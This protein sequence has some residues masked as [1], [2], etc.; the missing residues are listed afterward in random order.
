[1]QGN[2]ALFRI[3]IS[4]GVVTDLQLN[5]SKTGYEPVNS[6]IGQGFKTVST[7]W[8]STQA[9][10]PGQQLLLNIHEPSAIFTDEDTLVLSIAI[11]FGTM[12]A[13]GNPT[14]VRGAGAGKILLA[15]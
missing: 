8:Y 1:M 4:L 7:G 11:E 12:D 5:T 6:T 13:F 10:V 14:P 9:S 2:Y 15:G 3:S